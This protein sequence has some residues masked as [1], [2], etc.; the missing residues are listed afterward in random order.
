M[1]MTKDHKQL[2]IELGVE[3]IHFRALCDAFRSFLDY[4]SLN[5]RENEIVR[6]ILCGGKTL[7]AVGEKFNISRERTRQIFEKALRRAKSDMSVYMNNIDKLH[8]IDKLH[9]DLEQANQSILMLSAENL[10]LR[11]SLKAEYKSDIQPS[12]FTK[13]QEHVLYAPIKHLETISIRLRNCLI[14]ANIETLSEVLTI[15]TAD[16]LKYHGFGRK[17]LTELR[18]YIEEIG[19]EWH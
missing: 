1:R 8:S 6:E 4:I 5:P 15:R 11:Q 17:S 2:A 16:L 7:T 13:E 18:E 12:G 14:S 19:L 9:I 3:P 10:K